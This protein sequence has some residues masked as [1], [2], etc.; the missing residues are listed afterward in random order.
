[1]SKDTDLF[2]IFAPAKLK[3]NMKKLVMLALAALVAVPVFAQ[4]EKEPIYSSPGGNF[5]FDVL[6]HVGYGFNATKS[7]DFKPRFSYDLFANVLKF[8]VYPVP[9]LGLE[10]GVDV[11][12]N[13]FGSKESA[14]ALDSDNKIRAIDFNKLSLGVFNNIDKKRS[15]F[16]VFSLSAPLLLKG[17][18]GKFE[19]GAGAEAFWNVAGSTYAFVRQDNC[20]MTFSERKA[21]INPFTYAI[22]GSISYNQVGFFVK[23]YPKSSRLLPEGSVDLSFTT[24]GFAIGF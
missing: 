3:T 22:L 6:G 4:V 17:I 14:F 9:V 1:M 15:D 20:D 23:V 13:N 2:A 16:G 18:F 8:G 10:L 12:L 11:E 24:I 21:K 7:A 5:K 19:L